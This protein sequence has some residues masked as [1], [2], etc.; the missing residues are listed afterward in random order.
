LKVQ[1]KNKVDNDND[2][3][4]LL[5]VSLSMPKR[6]TLFQCLITRVRF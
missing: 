3:S 5:E 4:A 6:I 2:L 1:I